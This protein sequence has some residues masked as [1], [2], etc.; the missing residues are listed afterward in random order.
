M[1][2]TQRR[3]LGTA[4]DCLTDALSYLEA[5]IASTPEPPH[6]PHLIRA[7]ADINDTLTGLMRLYGE[8]APD[9]HEHGGRVA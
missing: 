1:N 5:L 7:Q 3:Q 9:E 2:R 4:L 6:L 8:P